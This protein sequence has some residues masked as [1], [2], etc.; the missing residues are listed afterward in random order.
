MNTKLTMSER[1]RAFIEH[2]G[3][4]ISDFGK[5]IGATKQQVS[6]WVGGRPI[7]MARLKLIVDQFSE[8]NTHWLISGNGNM[9]LGKSSSVSESAI[10]N[11]SDPE[12]RAEIDR[13]KIEIEEKNSLIIQLQNEKIKWLEA[14]EKS[15]ND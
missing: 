13:L 6:D 5:R 8:L 9:I 12:C 7:P 4:S 1:L 2:T 11:C 14:K 3:L 10:Q 15:I